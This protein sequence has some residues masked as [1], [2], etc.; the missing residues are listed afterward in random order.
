MRPIDHNNM[1]WLVG[2]HALYLFTKSLFE[3]RSTSYGFYCCTNSCLS[4]FYIEAVEPSL[5]S[6]KKKSKLQPD[7]I[8][9]CFAEISCLLLWT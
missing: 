1:W 6:M 4:Y 3:V 8:M 5:L 2:K 9:L 7:K